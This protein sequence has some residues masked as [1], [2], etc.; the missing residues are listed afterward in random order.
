MSVKNALMLRSKNVARKDVMPLIYNT[1]E[2]YYSLCRRD[3]GNSKPN[4]KYDLWGSFNIQ[5]RA[6]LLRPFQFISFLICPSS[7]LACF[8][9]QLRIKQSIKLKRRAKSHNKPGSG[10]L[11]AAGRRVL[12]S[13][14]ICNVC[15]PGTKKVTRINYHQAITQTSSLSTLPSPSLHRASPPHSCS[16]S[17]FP[18]VTELSIAI[19]LPA[20]DIKL[21]KYSLKEK[22]CIS[23]TAVKNAAAAILNEDKEIQSCFH[24]IYTNK[25]T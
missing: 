21:L 3:R 17:P 11:A 19:M 18:I 23:F 24:F 25:S 16:L 8:M 4:N 5:T 9:A 1:T 12:L 13:P 10:P 22:K 7:F 15:C 2:S 20:W 14:V 6:F